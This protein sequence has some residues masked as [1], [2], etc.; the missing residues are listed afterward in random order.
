M[1]RRIL[2]AALTAALA[3][4]GA[5]TAAPAAAPV[6]DAVWVAGATGGAVSQL[7]YGDSFTAG[8]T[9]RA[10]QPWAYAECRPMATTVLGTPNQGTYTPGDVMWSEYRSVYA[11]GPVPAPFQLTDPIQGLW[12]GGGATCTLSLIK[13]SGGGYTKKTVLATTSFT[14]AP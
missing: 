10:S 4:L 1:S 5:P 7:H 11:G 2:A 12:L 9:T 6:T 13:W 8:Y 14:V 3:V